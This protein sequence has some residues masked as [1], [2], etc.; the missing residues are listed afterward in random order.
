MQWNGVLE[1]FDNRQSPYV[2]NQQGL[3][4]GLAIYFKLTVCAGVSQLTAF[5]INTLSQQIV[6]T[7]SLAGDDSSTLTMSSERISVFIANTVDSLAVF[8][9][10]Y[11]FKKLPEEKHELLDS[12]KMVSSLESEKVLGAIKKLKNLS[13]ESDPVVEAW[14]GF[15]YMLL[16]GESMVKDRLSAQ[17]AASDYILSALSRA[18]GHPFVLAVAGHFFTF[19][20]R[21]FQYA[22][23]LL[24]KAMSIAPNMAVVRDTRGLLCLY[25]DDFETA[26]HH[27]DYAVKLSS[28]NSLKNYIAASK[29]MLL[30]NLGQHES[31]VNLAERI[32]YQ[33]PD[34]EAVKRYAFCSLAQ[35]GELSKAEPLFE[36]IVHRSPG[37]LEKQVKSNH[38]P[39]VSESFSRL[40]QN[41][42]KIFA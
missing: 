17:L 31:S 27:I 18:P 37:L 23:E 28:A 8:V 7:E 39:L 35:I 40:F 1:L 36:Q 25:N 14:L 12:I 30:T 32:L 11:S 21:D 5:A 16:C 26:S 41:S 10:N 19:Y 24:R 22:D 4:V 3:H 2:Q 29:V 42:A 9:A 13:S 20:K 33:H 15:A 6:W 38:T 34:F